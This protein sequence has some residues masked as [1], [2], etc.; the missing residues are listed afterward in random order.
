MVEA[1]G[2]HPHCQLLEASFAFSL[3]FASP[4]PPKNQ[5]CEERKVNKKQ[6]ATRHNNRSLSIEQ[7]VTDCGKRRGCSEERVARNELFVGIP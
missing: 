2:V 4:P 6:R 7:K 1:L 3:T 5:I